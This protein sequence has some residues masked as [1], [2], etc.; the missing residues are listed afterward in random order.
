[1]SFH[2]CLLSCCPDFEEKQ[3]EMKKTTSVFDGDTKVAEHDVVLD[4]GDS[5]C[6]DDNMDEVCDD[7]GAEQDEDDVV[8]AADSEDDSVDSADADETSEADGVRVPRRDVDADLH[9]LEDVVGTT[10]KYD[11][12]ALELHESVAVVVLE[13][14]DEDEIAD[15]AESDRCSRDS[16]V[17]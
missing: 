13:L 11:G 15:E 10:G 3:E 16:A 8:D 4:F 5:E 17:D 7:E 6:V 1:M 2:S 12:S 14:G 9:V